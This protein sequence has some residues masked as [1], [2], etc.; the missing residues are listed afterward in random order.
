MLDKL[1]GYKTQVRLLEKQL[2]EL[3]PSK[4]HDSTK[5]KE[6]TEL[7]KNLKDIIKEKEDKREERRKKKEEA[8]KVE[9][10]PV[11]ETPK[12]EAAATP[13]EVVK[14][15]L[16]TPTEVVKESSVEKW[17]IDAKVESSRGTGSWGYIMR[18]DWADNNP[19][20]LVYVAWQEGPLKERD[21][22]GGYYKN[23]LK[24]KAEEIKAEVNPNLV[25]RENLQVLEADYKGNLEKMIKDL[26]EE[27]KT[28]LDKGEA[29]WAARLEQKLN[30]AKQ[31]Y[32]DKFEKQADFNGVCDLCKGK[33]CDECKQCHQC[34]KITGEH[35]NGS[36][37]T[38]RL[39]VIDQTPAHDKDP[40][41]K[42]LGYGGDRAYG[43]QTAPK[44]DESSLPLE[45]SLESNK[46][47]AFEKAVDHLDKKLTE[48]ELSQS[49]YDKQYEEL[50]KQHKVS[51]LNKKS[52][53]IT[54]GEK[55][56]IVNPLKKEIEDEFNYNV[57]SGANNQK[58]FKITSKDELG[59][60]QLTAIIGKELGNKKESSTKCAIC[61]VEFHSYPEYQKHQ[62]EVHEHKE[63]SP[64]DPFKKKDIVDRFEKKTPAIIGRLTGFVYYKTNS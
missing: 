59:Q 43:W 13:T 64:M 6:V 39:K 29:V 35:E 21:I 4:K 9:S 56:F 46:E 25:P 27:H 57:S 50:K 63:Y 62:A 48:H 17:A 38:T 12:V 47:I 31:A 10:K 16:T 20:G 28:A 49:E 33:V 30:D 24:L 53:N 1:A 19:N 7:L 32:K 40:Q 11:E 3:D 18:N 55:L 54:V 15:S 5:M 41:E 26:E 52:I 23:D 45:S 44:S 8:A 61:G 36:G 37:G 22:F 14:E 58:L 2:K 51:S 34:V 60:E 42:E